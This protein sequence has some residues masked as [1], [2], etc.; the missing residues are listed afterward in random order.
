V[1]WRSFVEQGLV[2]GVACLTAFNSRWLVLTLKPEDFF[3]RLAHEVAY[4]LMR[5]AARDVRHWIEAERL[6]ERVL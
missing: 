3:V 1:T 2:V 4:T 6:R 5:E